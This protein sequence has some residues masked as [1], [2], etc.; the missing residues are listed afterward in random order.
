MCPSLCTRLPI[1]SFTLSSTYLLTRVPTHSCTYSTSDVFFSFLPSFRPSVLPS[2][3]PSFR[4]PYLLICL[5]VCLY[6]DP[7]TYLPICLLTDVP[8]HVPPTHSL[9]TFLPT[10]RSTYTSTFLVLELPTR[11]NFLISKS[12]EGLEHDVSPVLFTRDLRPLFN[13]KKTLRRS[14]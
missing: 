2:F 1:E 13:P 12:S 7:S 6:T 14:S 9:D 8:T 10:H 11:W 4:S 3:L 5:S